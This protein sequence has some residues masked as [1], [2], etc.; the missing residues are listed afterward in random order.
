MMTSH[1]GRRFVDRCVCKLA[2]AGPLREGSA[3]DSFWIPF[4]LRY[5]SDNFPW[6][7]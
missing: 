5:A 7:F 3:H 2:H 1:W 6:T 4:L